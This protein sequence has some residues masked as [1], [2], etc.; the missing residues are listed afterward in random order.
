MGVDV[1]EGLGKDASVIQIFDITDLSK[2]EQVAMYHSNLIDPTDF[3]VVVSDIAKMY[4]DWQIKG[5]YV[6]EQALQ[7]S[8]Y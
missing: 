6:T 4:G 5:F 7:S 2:I 8:L 3:T 1:A